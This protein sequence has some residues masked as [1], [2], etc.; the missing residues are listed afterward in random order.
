MKPNPTIPDADAPVLS[1]VCGLGPGWHSHLVGRQEIIF[2]GGGSLW[3]DVY[4]NT[5]VPTSL[6]TWPRQLSLDPDLSLRKN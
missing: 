6:P 4:I 5:R 3:L 2:N 1:Y